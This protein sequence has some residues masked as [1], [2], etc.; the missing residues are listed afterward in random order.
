MSVEGQSHL[1]QDRLETPKKNGGFFKPSPLPAQSSHTLR[2]PSP[3]KQMWN[4]ASSIVSAVGGV[5]GLSAEKQSK[6]MDIE[7]GNH[8]GSIHIQKNNSK[9]DLQAS[10]H[11]SSSQWKMHRGSL[12]HN[13]NLTPTFLPNNKNSFMERLSKKADEVRRVSSH[14]EA[15]V[16]HEYRTNPALQ[17]LEGIKNSFSGNN[18]SQSGQNSARQSE[19]AAFYQS[20]I[21]EEPQPKI[22]HHLTDYHLDTNF[23]SQNSSDHSQPSLQKAASDPNLREKIIDERQINSQYQQQSSSVTKPVFQSL[24]KIPPTIQEEQRHE[25]SLDFTKPADSIGFGVAQP[26]QANQP[27]SFFDHHPVDNNKPPTII[28]ESQDSNSNS[29]PTYNL[30]FPTT[31]QKL[32]AE[33]ENSADYSITD[34]SNSSDEADRTEEWRDAADADFSPESYSKTKYKQGLMAEIGKVYKMHPHEDF[35]DIK[36]FNS[37]SGLNLTKEEFDKI[38]RASKTPVRPPHSSVPKKKVLFINNKR[39][40]TWA[41]DKEALRKKVL[42]QNALGRYKVTFGK[43]KPLKQLDI[44]EFF[45]EKLAR[46]YHP[47][48]DERFETPQSA[49]LSPIIEDESVFNTI[50]KEHSVS[51]SHFHN[52]LSLAKSNFKKPPYM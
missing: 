33:R 1:A 13:E 43:V 50:A 21:G 14:I 7:S 46:L 8:P 42:A 31:S 27:I 9:S 2:N 12:P 41:T 45:P 22:Q 10:G 16:D 48:P 35:S 28:R 5:L 34:Y 26:A 23:L 6:R 36:I 20:L 47:V 3:I 19:G 15:E 40:P 37:K 49:E 18:R 4:Y 38:S 29:V 39:V 24:K 52:N 32:E 44:S 11:H 30:P 25:M 51:K 17:T